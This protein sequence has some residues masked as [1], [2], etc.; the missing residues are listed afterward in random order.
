M[1][2]LRYNFFNFVKPESTEVDS[3][4]TLISDVSA[5]AGFGLPDGSITT[6]PSNVLLNL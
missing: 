3:L 1:D 4:I 5:A 2:G 6:S